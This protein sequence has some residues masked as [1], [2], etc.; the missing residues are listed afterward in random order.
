MVS[1]GS[2]SRRL[3]KHF[4]AVCIFKM[5]EQKLREVLE[6]AGW[7]IEDLPAAQV[8]MSPAGGRVRVDVRDWVTPC[9]GYSILDSQAYIAYREIE[10]KLLREAA[11][12]LLALPIFNEDKD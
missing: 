10:D 1:W 7:T 5:I 6:Q 9:A 12:E 11:Q 8:C 4:T 3:H 2:S